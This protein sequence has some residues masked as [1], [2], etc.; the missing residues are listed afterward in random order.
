MAHKFFLEF[1]RSWITRQGPN[2][3]QTGFGL[4]GQGRKCYSFAIKNNEEITP[5]RVQ[6][7]PVRHHQY[8]WLF[9]P[10]TIL[11]SRSIVYPC[12]RGKCSL[13]CPCRICHK[14][15]AKCRAGQSCDCDDCRL[16]YEDHSNFHA[17]RHMGC[18]HC[19][20]IVT[21]LPQF[22]F[23]FLDMSKKICN[24]GVPF[25]EQLRPTYE[26]PPVN[27][28]LVKR[29]LVSEKWSEKLENWNHNVE[30][31][32]I[33]CKGCSTMFFDL[34]MLREHLLSKH[35]VSK[36]FHHNC[37][38]D[39]TRPLPGFSC[40]Q[41]SGSFRSKG[42]MTRHLE[43]K[44][45]KERFECPDCSITFSRLDRFRMHRKNKHGN[46]H[47]PK[48]I[49]L[50]CEVCEKSFSSKSAKRR[51]TREHCN[52][53]SKVF[54]LGC[55][56]CDTTFIR[57]HD[58]KRHKQNSVNPDG[59]SKLICTLCDERVCNRKLLMG[60]IKAKHGS[61]KVGKVL[62]ESKGIERKYICECEFCGKLFERE[63]DA[64]IHKVTHNVA[65]KIQCEIC[66]ASFSLKKNYKRHQKEAFLDNGRTKHSCPICEKAFCTERLL[67]GH[68]RR[69]HDKFVCPICNQV[70]TFKHNLERHVGI[71]VAVTCEQCE[72][73][74]CNRKAYYEHMNSDHLKSVI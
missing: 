43:S 38:N 7:V 72:K 35:S 41:C 50:K 61:S 26:L 55:D 63:K 70:F 25:E 39:E 34:K 51:H 14:I 28:D 13:P 5:E 4:K 71:R 17:C 66:K 49:S 20:N 68:M 42:D 48:V 30:D 8:P 16:H 24:S 57:D 11:S 37:V 27:K 67:K 73:V 74:Y 9:G 36:V 52:E 40:D 2:L 3:V 65:D 60:H 69:C 1:N 47:Q 46:V 18:R 45:F 64:M 59:S 33:W 10:A 44:H 19:H 53:E 22:N 56:D 29:F 62:E 54:V 6:L 58:L 31:D 15:H 21:G 12:S 32:G 23:F